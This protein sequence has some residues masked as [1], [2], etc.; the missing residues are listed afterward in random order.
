MDGEIASSKRSQ[1]HG[2]RKERRLRE[3]GSDIEMIVSDIAD[4]ESFETIVIGGRG[5]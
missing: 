1:Q 2:G 4:C 5:C 3:G